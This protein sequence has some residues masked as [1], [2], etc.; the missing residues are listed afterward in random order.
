M[1]RKTDYVV[2]AKAFMNLDPIEWAEPEQDLADLIE[3]A[4]TGV[5]LRVLKEACVSR[6]YKVMAFRDPLFLREE[7][8][9][10][11]C[12]ATRDAVIC[13][14]VQ[15]SYDAGTTFQNPM[16]DFPAH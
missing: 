3:R 16:D 5:E 11:W 8:V 4:Q 6:E 7:W 1:R 10:I 2:Q 9:E 12:T 15:I 13:F 14:A